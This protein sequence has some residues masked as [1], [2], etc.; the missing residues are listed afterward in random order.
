MAGEKCRGGGVSRE[1]R[2]MVVGAQIG[3]G[4]VADGDGGG[5]LGVGCVRQ[6]LL[7]DPVGLCG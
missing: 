2:V 1:S 4:M 7:V 5:W 6:R 3:W